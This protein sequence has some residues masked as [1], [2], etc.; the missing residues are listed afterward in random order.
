MCDDFDWHRQSELKISRGLLPCFVTM[1]L[2][3]LLPSAESSCSPS[4][5]R[6]PWKIPLQSQK[7]FFLIR[8]DQ[9]IFWYRSFQQLPLI[10]VSCKYHPPSMSSYFSAWLRRMFLLAVFSLSPDLFLSQR[11]VA[12]YPVEDY[13]ETSGDCWVNTLPHRGLNGAQQINHLQLDISVLFKWLHST[14]TLWDRD[15]DLVC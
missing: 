15:I 9:K 4:R 10:S 12:V 11:C 14:A 2:S 3:L 6:M 13:M 7:S 5:E 8:R 1:F